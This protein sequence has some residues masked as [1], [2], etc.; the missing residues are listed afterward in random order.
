MTISEIYEMVKIQY[1]EL[2]ESLFLALFNKVRERISKDVPLYEKTEEFSVTA[3]ENEYD[4]DT[5]LSEK[6][7][8]IL[9]LEY[10]GLKIDKTSL[11][12]QVET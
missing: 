7:S 10:N 3:D 4:L 5:V 11:D 6:L 1:P 2:T 9:R 8:K 12:L